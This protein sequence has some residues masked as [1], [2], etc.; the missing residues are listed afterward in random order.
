MSQELLITNENQEIEETIVK[1]RSE[2]KWYNFALK[3]FCDFWRN[4]WKQIKECFTGQSSSN[5]NHHWQYQFDGLC[6]DDEESTYHT[7]IEL[8]QPPIEE[9]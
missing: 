9:I 5:K 8:Y 1:L 2:S 4:L 6:D 7:T 3:K